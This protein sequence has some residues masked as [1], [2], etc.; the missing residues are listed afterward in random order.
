[1]HVNTQTH[2]I[3][4]NKTSKHQLARDLRSFWFIFDSL[5]TAFYIRDIF[6]Y[7]ISIVKELSA[8]RKG[9]CYFI[10][11]APISILPP[12]DLTDG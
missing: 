5:A 8:F 1:M 4:R 11:Q 3:F 6:K 2:Q 7:I 10:V 12:N 9:V